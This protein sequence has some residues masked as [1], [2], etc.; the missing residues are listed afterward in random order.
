MQYAL[1]RQLIVPDIS[2]ANAG[3]V[4]SALQGSLAGHPDLLKLVNYKTK[5]QAAYY[6]KQHFGQVEWG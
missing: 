1:V 6:A 5:A 4:L 2:F 3:A